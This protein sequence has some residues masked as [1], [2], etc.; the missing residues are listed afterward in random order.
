MK[1]YSEVEFKNEVNRIYNGEI[2]VVGRYKSI[3]QP[4]L[5]KDRYGVMSLPKAS[6]ILLNKPGI[7]AALNPT[8]YFMNQ[9]KEVYPEIAEEV[10][11][12]SEYK[13]MKQKMLFDTKFGLVSINPDALIHGHKPNVRSAINRKEYMRN[14]LLYLYDN[15][16]D[17]IIDSTDRHSGRIRLICPIHGEVSVDSCHIFSGC[18]CPKCNE[19]MKKSDHLYVIRLFS[20]SETFYKL[21]ITYLNNDTPRRFKDYKKLGYQIEV[22]KL[23]KF[24]TYELCHEKEVKLKRL[25]RKNLYYPKNWPNSTSEECFTKDLLEIIIENI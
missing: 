9:L 21:G 5:V 25:I 4:I 11:P 19:S 20:N 13:T 17:F 22:L 8:E 15:K 2:E 10:R 23:I 7:K 12:A 3:S 6:Q 18:G 24:D 14:Q 16:Y 1:K